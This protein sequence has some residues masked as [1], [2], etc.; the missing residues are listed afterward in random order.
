MVF[1][2]LEKVLDFTGAGVRP[3]ALRSTIFLVDPKLN[4]LKKLNRDARMIEP[5]GCK[6]AH[7]TAMK[8]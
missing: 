8:V 1:F 2:E 5:I 4:I 7:I 3:S 6:R